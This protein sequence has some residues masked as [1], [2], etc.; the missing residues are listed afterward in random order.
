MIEA[1]VSVSFLGAVT[2][3][4]GWE[5]PIFSVASG[6]RPER[7]GKN[8]AKRDMGPDTSYMIS[9]PSASRTASTDAIRSW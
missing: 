3:C 8:R 1:V 5:P 4:F 2:V 9:S 7:G 6:P